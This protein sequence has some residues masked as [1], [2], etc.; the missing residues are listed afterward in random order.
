MKTIII[1]SVIFLIV[2]IKRAAF[3]SNEKS[4]YRDA[5]QSRYL[6]KKI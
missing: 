6:S 3:R 1:I 2:L 5:L 4:I